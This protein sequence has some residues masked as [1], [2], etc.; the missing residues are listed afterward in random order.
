LEE[1]LSSGLRLVALITVPAAFGLAVLR[2]P[3]VRVLFE[4]G[5]FDASSTAI[6][7]AA[8]LYY[9]IGIIALAA[10]SVMTF[11]FY[12]MQ[13]TVTPVVITGIGVTANIALD[14]ALVGPMAHS[15]LALANTVSAV[16]IMLLLIAAL[17]RKLGGLRMSNLTLTF[18]KVVSAASVMSIVAY[19]LAT[20]LGLFAGEGGLGAQAMA[21]TVTIAAAGAVYGLLIMVMKVEEVQLVLGFVRRKVFGGRA[22]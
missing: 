15:G 3:I 20:R 18:A 16:L 22:G 10:N 7:A 11:T 13:D 5:A 2:E 12:G 4:R 19:L 21:V 9:S 17:G 6:T 8:V 1:T 14:F